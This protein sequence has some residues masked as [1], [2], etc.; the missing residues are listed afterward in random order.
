LKKYWLFIKNKA[1]YIPII[2]IIG[3][4]LLSYNIYKKSIEVPTKPVVS[5]VLQDSL[6]VYNDK[7][8]DASNKAKEKTVIAK[9]KHIL[10][11]EK[12]SEISKIEDKDLRSI[13][14]AELAKRDDVAY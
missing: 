11:K 9:K 7:I 1:L 13:K 5:T 8:K 2:S 14:L 6:K 3:I 10:V 12:L 4:L